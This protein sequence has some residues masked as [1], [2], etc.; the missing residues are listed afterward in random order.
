MGQLDNQTAIVTGGG[1]GIGFE[2]AKLFHQ[3]GANVVLSSRKEEV[4]VEAAGRIS[5]DQSRILCVRADI[6]EEQDVIELM[7]R[8][9][10]W[11]GQIDVLINN[12]GSN[13]INKPPE[14]TSLAEWKSVMD[15]NVTGTFLCCREAGKVMI[16]QKSGRIVNIS[17]LSS[18][19]VNKYFHGGSY[20]VSKSA[21]NMLTKVFAVEWAPHNITVN[22]V[23]PGYYG[24]QP[25]IDFFSK[26]EGL[27]E[28]VLDMIPM[29][30][31]GDLEE[32]CGFLLY[33]ATNKT[34]YM[35]GTTI[36]LDGGY[37]LW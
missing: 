22:A 15:T 10:Q 16:P 13:R 25:N 17:S 1:T 27:S 31:L 32:L 3:E 5:S 24:T 20:E 28:K 37:S 7:Q 36:P 2:V 18:F 33:L 29:K 4:I 6:A 9:K 14:E 34:G 8:T 11:S 26:E 23:A 19:I 21:I 30:K 12:A 35:N